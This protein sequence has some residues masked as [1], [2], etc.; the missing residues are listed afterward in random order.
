[1]IFYIFNATRRIL[2]SDKLASSW[3][4]RVN[5]CLIAGWR[6]DLHNIMQSCNFNARIMLRYENRNPKFPYE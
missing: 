6:R 1:M 3:A 4:R 5:V 2:A